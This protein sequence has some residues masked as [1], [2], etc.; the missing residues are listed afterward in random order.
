M[1]FAIAKLIRIEKSISNSLSIFFP[2]IY[3]TRNISFSLNYSIPIFFM[4]AAAFV[5]N[6]INDL[7]KDKINHSNRALPKN[8]I[9][10][11]MAII[12]YYF[13][14]A[15]ALLSIKLTVPFNYVFIYLLY[16]VLITNYDYLN[17]GYPYLKN[18]YVV[19][20][21]SIHFAILYLIIPINIFILI[22]LVINILCKEIYMDIR[23]IKGD[24]KTFAKVMGIKNTGK[25]ILC[26]QF[27]LLAST[28][29]V[30]YQEFSIIHCLAFII[31]VI[32]F[33]SNAII[34]YRYNVLNLKSNINII[35]F[36][37][38]IIYGLIL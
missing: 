15:G 35:V 23:D 17:M 34:W 1:L 7:E 21:F 8:D 4:F 29:T 9:S 22:G 33:I 28:F 2:L 30:L 36:Q 19:L 26:L 38:F 27:L 13:F 24:G 32:T 6:D 18:L 10:I 31:V 37:N 20:V 12:L 16:I 5:I 3:I 14:L 11:N 25:V